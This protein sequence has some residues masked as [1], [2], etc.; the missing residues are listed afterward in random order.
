MKK[1]ICEEIEKLRHKDGYIQAGAPRFKG[2]F[3]RDSLIVSWQLINYDSSIAE[4]TL[5]ALASLQGTKENIKTGEEPGKILHEY[6]PIETPDDWWEK[7]KEPISWLKRGNPVYMSVDSTPLFLIVF[8][9]YLQKTK[10]YNLTKKLQKNIVAAT[11]WMINYGDKDRDLFLEYKKVSPEGLDHQAWKDSNMRQLNMKPP[12]AMVEVQGYQYFALIASSKMVKN[13]KLAKKCLNRARKLKAE[14]NK[15][16]WSPKNNF[17]VLALDKDK[18]PIDKITSNPGHLI[19]TGILTKDRTDKVVKRLFQKDMMTKYGIRTYS[20]KEQEFETLS[21]HMG[22]VWSHDNWIIAQGLK[23]KGYTKEYNK[24][25]RS[26][27][28]A[29][30]EIGFLP[31]LYGVDKNNNMVKRKDACYPQAWASGAILSFLL[32]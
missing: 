6:Y 8:Y 23:Q 18:K 2:L 31:E 32:D 7:Y 24:I 15:K 14:F 11:N 9:I 20:D 13:K 3:G 22:T 26:I 29:R 17:Y 19:F 5:L 25:K 16:F 10:N 28:K 12:I 4:N 21:Y 30:K 1:E 27:I